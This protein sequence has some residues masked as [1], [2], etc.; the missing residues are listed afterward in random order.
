MS[1]AP[2]LTEHLA[3]VRSALPPP[4]DPR[5]VAPGDWQFLGDLIPAIML[6]AECRLAVPYLPP[7]YRRQRAEARHRVR[8]QER[9][10]AA[11]LRE[12][13]RARS[14]APS[15]VVYRNDAPRTAP[16]KAHDLPPEQHEAIE[17]AVRVAGARFRLNPEDRWDLRQELALKLL[18]CQARI[19]NVEA[20]LCRVALN[21]AANFARDE[22]RRRELRDEAR[23]R[24]TCPRGARILDCEPWGLPGNPEAALIECI[25]E[26]AENGEGPAR[27][28]TCRQDLKAEQTI[29]EKRESTLETKKVSVRIRAG[30][31]SL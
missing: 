26:R 10:R 19:S 5:T 3:R 27:T 1:A 20:W 12:Q 28:P 8:A 17:H 21:S 4:I 13:H 18:E 30:V 16:P 14:R 15:L 11:E 25:D 6:R 24:D 2:N 7:W 9:E 23:R 22:A 31:S 29:R